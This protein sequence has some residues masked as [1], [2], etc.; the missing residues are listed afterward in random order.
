MTWAPGLP[1]TIRDKL[2]RAGGWIERRGV[3]CF[4]LYRA[5]I[6]EPGNPE[7]AAPWINHVRLIYPDEADHII[8]WLAHRVQR[9]Q[10]KINHALVLGGQQGI[11][12]DTLLEPVKYAIGPW[13]LHEVS[14]K[15]VL[16]RFNGFLKAV[17]PDSPDEMAFGHLRAPILAIRSS[18][19]DGSSSGIMTDPTGERRNPQF[20]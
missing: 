17:I 2:I 15:Q 18:S 9:P 1:I 16:G 4:N 8:D 6:I 11:G 13:N 7:K 20:R 12:K 19:Y 10:E 5:P 3:T 14:P